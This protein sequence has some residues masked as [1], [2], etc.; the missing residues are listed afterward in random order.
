[1]QLAQLVPVK[2]FG[3]WHQIPRFFLLKAEPVFASSGAVVTKIQGSVWG[4]QDRASSSQVEK[5]R[6]RIERDYGL[7]R[8]LQ[9]ELES[10]VSRFLFKENTVGANAEALQCLRK[11]PPGT[12]GICD[13]YAQFV[14]ELVGRESA[15][16]RA[17]LKVQMYFAEN[18]SMI[19]KKGQAYM[20]ECWE[21]QDVFDFEARRV[22][23]TDHDSLSQCTE[24]LE[25]VFLEA[26]DRVQEWK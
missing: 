1:M 7:T 23:G 20:E 19:G 2:V 9:V 11:G 4:G 25:R 3:V 10:L 18:D 26:K 22:L 14:R 17:R 13:D 8:D 21:D 6:R 5:T 12:W 24:I 15:D 16:R